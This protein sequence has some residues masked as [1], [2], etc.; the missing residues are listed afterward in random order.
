M[1][2]FRGGPWPYAHARSRRV[3]S[4]ASEVRDRER[5]VAA[6]QPFERGREFHDEDGSRGSQRAAGWPPGCAAPPRDRRHWGRGTAT[7]E[8]HAVVALHEQNRARVELEGI[9]GLEA[10]EPGPTRT[11]IRT[12]PFERRRRPRRGALFRSQ[13]RRGRVVQPAPA[14]DERG[15]GARAHALDE[16]GRERSAAAPGKRRRQLLVSYDFHAH[17]LRL[18]GRPG[19]RVRRDSGAAQGDDDLARVAPRPGA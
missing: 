10:L 4:F 18:D 5:D 12:P 9:V 1:V 3:T 13:Q 14:L 16:L 7:R 11:P 6:P 8:E 19:R 2:R 17:I 15:A